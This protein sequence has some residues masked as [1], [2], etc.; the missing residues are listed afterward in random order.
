MKIY[1]SSLHF[2][3]LYIVLC[4]TATTVSA[5]STITS[6][7][8]RFGI[9]EL[10]PQYNLRSSAMGGIAQG[11]NNPGEINFANPASYASF[12]SLT[13]LFDFAF[14]GT[15]NTLKTKE[16]SSRTTNASVNYIIIGM[17]VTKWWRTTIGLTP[18]SSVGYSVY[19]ESIHEGM[20][21]VQQYYIGEGSYNRAFWGNSFRLFKNLSIG[22]NAGYLFGSGNRDRL[23]HFI[24]SANIRTSNI[25][26][27]VYLKDFTFEP[28]FQYSANLTTKD[29]LTIG[30]TVS[31]PK[32]MK[33]ERTF[34]VFSDYNNTGYYLDTIEYDQSTGDVYLPT[35]LNAGFSYQRDDRLTIG[36]DFYWANWAKYTVFGENDSL[37]NT[38]GLSVGAEFIPS[39]KPAAKYGQ[40]MAYR[41]GF[42]TRQQLLQVQPASYD[43]PVNVN[44]YAVTFG[45][46]LPI[47]RSRTKI[48]FY[49][50]WGVKGTT[51]YDLFKDN[52]FKIGAGLSLSEMW[53]MKRQYR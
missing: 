34:F 42:R 33:A 30:A 35:I 40:K 25:L 46:G 10:S 36:A 49:M 29:R 8:S 6:P 18:L 21:T 50:E 38:W 11:L 31:I 7:Y 4:I 26:N 44:E 39:N 5:Q 14:H 51:K 37:Q 3:L 9:G 45:L 52:Y 19:D 48:N 12:D 28:G 41:V 13:F 20:G 53:F 47:T 2:F 16:S 1:K 43:E 17:P 27:E 15:F 23:L 32:K 24:D 22:I